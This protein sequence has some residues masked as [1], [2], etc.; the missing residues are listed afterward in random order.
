MD[1]K[2]EAYIK[3]INLTAVPIHIEVR[4]GLKS[5]DNFFPQEPCRPLPG[6]D[7]THF[8]VPLGFEY[9]VCV[10]PGEVGTTRSHV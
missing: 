10:N 9:V 7:K 3:V 4:S 6:N 1:A 8:V 2:N 5:Y